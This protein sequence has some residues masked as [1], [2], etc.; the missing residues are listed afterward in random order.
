MGFA[1]QIGTRY[2][3]SSSGRGKETG[4]FET[5]SIREWRGQDVV[6]TQGHKI[7]ELEAVYVG[8]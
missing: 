1:N 4:M 6:D 3:N 2:S 7:G 5:A 8:V